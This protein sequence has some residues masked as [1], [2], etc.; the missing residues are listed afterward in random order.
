MMKNEANALACY[1]SARI[2]G[3]TLDSFFIIPHFSSGPAF[4]RDEG[5]GYSTL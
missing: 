2:R 5:R 3:D 1:L 4:R